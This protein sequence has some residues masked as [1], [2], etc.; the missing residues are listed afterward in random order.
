MSM[1]RL[2]NSMKPLRG[3]NRNGGSTCPG[4]CYSL[5]FEFPNTTFSFQLRQ[6][7]GRTDPF[8]IN[9]SDQL[10]L[11]YFI[12]VG[13][14]EWIVRSHPPLRRLHVWQQ[15]KGAA[16]KFLP[17]RG[18]D[19]ILLYKLRNNCREADYLS[20]CQKRILELEWIP[21]KWIPLCTMSPSFTST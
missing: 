8:S 16:W 3:L 20:V 1:K 11:V 21:L 10:I 14:N 17:T 15:S 12:M 19:R 4:K 6:W 18:M 2:I 5:G 9:G 13:P 7:D